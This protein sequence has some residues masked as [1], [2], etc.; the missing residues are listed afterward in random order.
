MLVRSLFSGKKDGKKG[1]KDSSSASSTSTTQTSSSSSSS[2][3]KGSG[4]GRGKKGGQQQQKWEADIQPVNEDKVTLKTCPYTNVYMR[5]E[6]ELGQYA[7]PKNFFIVFA[8][9]NS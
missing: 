5:G 3:A 1:G 2:K 8:F 4:R 9:L 7:A 6:K